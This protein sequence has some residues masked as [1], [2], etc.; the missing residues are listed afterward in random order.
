MSENIILLLALTAGVMLIWVV[1]KLIKNVLVSL[2]CGLVAAG[3]L[4]WTLPRLSE[5]DDLVGETARRT[6]ELTEQAGEAARQIGKDATRA[7]DQA[8]NLA[9]DARELGDKLGEQ[10]DS[11]RGGNSPSESP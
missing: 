4:W 9:G 11:V 8:R 3:I 1:L 2:V 10:L 5:R 6:G 7:V